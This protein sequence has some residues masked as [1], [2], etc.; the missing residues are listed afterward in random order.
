MKNIFL[1]GVAAA[2]ALAVSGFANAGLIIESEPNDTIATAQN[3]D[4]YFDLAFDINIENSLGINTSTLIPHVEI[5]GTLSD[6]ASYDV[7]SF[8][9]TVG[10]TAIFDID[11]GASTFGSCTNNGGLDAFLRLFDP[12]GNSIAQNDDVWLNI[13]TGSSANGTL[14]SYIELTLPTTGLF[15]IRV[16][17]CCENPVGINGD[18]VL[19]V[20]V[21][22][23]STSVPEPSSMAILAIGL[24]GLVSRKFNKQA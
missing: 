23:H 19:N 16:G 14:D 2:F 7:F 12:S 20:S 4:S 9:G 17:R 18:Y 22:N 6:T 24:L 10:S 3:I 5:Q 15:A 21:E 8:W 1:K 13:D 11:C